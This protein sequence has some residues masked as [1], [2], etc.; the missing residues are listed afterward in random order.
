VLLRWRMLTDQLMNDAGWWIDDIRITNVA[1][2]DCGPAVNRMPNA[3]DDEARTGSG[4]AV[5]IAVLANDTDPDEDDLTIAAV[6]DP[7]NGSITNHGS[8]VTYQPDAG[9]A[10]AD[11]FTYTISDGHG[12]TDT[13]RVTVRVNK[14]PVAN[15]D[16]VTANED[17]AATFDVLANDN[18]ADGDAL[19]VASITQPIHGS[20]SIN[21]DGSIAYMPHPNYSGG[22]SFTYT[23]SDGRD[24]DSASVIV[25]VANTNDPPSAVNDSASTSKNSAVIVAVLAND[26][27]ADGDA[28]RIDSV[29]RPANGTAAI[30]ADGSIR[31]KPKGGFTGNDSFTYTISDG[32]GGVSTASVSVGVVK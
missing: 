29:S 22:D 9:F 12:G 26:S 27:D 2:T 30:L 6:T 19:T 23:V 28:L 21:S 8:A 3:N 5:A 31:Y 16:S 10:G 14:P 18:D 32:R 25:T 7:P 11:V 20:A 4:A 1:D 15:D 17:H 24:S 13:A